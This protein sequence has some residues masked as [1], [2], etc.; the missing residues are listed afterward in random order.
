MSAPVA[1]FWDLEPGSKV[2]LGL[3][4]Q[5]KTLTTSASGTIAFL[6]GIPPRTV[7]DRQGY[8]QARVDYLNHLF[9]SHAYVVSSAANP[10]LAGMQLLLSRVIVLVTAK[11]GTDATALGSALASGLP[12]RPLEMHGLEQEMT[13]VGSDM[14][15]SLALANMRIYLLGGFLLTAIAIIAVSLT[16]YL[17][18]RRTL[19]LLRIRGVSPSEMW[20]F[21]VA[22]L[23]S[24]ALLGIL[25]G[26]ATAVVAGYGLASYVWRLREIRTVVQLLPTRLVP[27]E[28]TVFV[29]SLI[30]VLLVGVATGFSWWVFRQTAR[31]R[32]AA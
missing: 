1:E 24:P 6:P 29:L 19:A 11:N 2:T 10:K 17:E 7:N 26:V 18:D 13:K 32:I 31:Q 4:S 5:R 9:S 25:L 22:L 23:V 15:I 28:L 16:N 21:V 8:V 27:T 20:R 14:Y 3:D 30:V 12:Y